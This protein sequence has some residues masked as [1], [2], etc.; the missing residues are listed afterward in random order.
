MREGG[1]CIKLIQQAWVWYM[2]YNTG[3]LGVI[4]ENVTGI[5]KCFKGCKS[6]IDHFVDILKEHIPFFEWSV[7]TLHLK[8]YDRPQSR[9]RVFLRGI[10]RAIS[11]TVPA[12]LPPWKPVGDS[13]QALRSLL[14]KFPNTYRPLLTDK[15]QANLKADE[16]KI[17][18]LFNM[19]ELK[20][21][22]IA[23]VALD[24][25][26]GKEYNQTM[27]FNIVPTL[28]TH[29]VYLFLMSVG[30]IVG[31]SDLPSH[32]TISVGG[33]KD[34]SPITS[35]RFGT[36]MHVCKYVCTSVYIA[37]FETRIHETTEICG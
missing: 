28:T 25:A 34:P 13:P 5:L 15:M 20:A 35:E 27:R 6:T 11:N 33:H 30:C 3:L 31:I 12:V 17:C 36:R 37:S 10:R 2:A 18:E 19:N 1:V 21:E 29:N 9:S 22:D 24:R 14:G 7:D 26:E 8:D 16:R 4:L 32:Q 23:V